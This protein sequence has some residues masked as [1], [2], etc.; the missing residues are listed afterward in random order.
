MAELKVCV[1]S[2]LLRRNIASTS[3]IASHRRESRRWKKI[4]ES[5]AIPKLAH[6]LKEKGRRMAMDDLPRRL[7]TAERRR[8]GFMVERGSATISGSTTTHNARSPYSHRTGHRP[9]KPDTPERLNGTRMKTKIPQ[10]AWTIRCKFGPNNH[11]HCLS[12]SICVIKIQPGLAVK[13]I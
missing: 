9:M 13:I 10:I 12:I 4:W 3:F 11:M 5:R 2:G 8:S 7:G 6:H 1:A